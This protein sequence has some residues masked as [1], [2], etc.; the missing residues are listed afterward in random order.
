MFFQLLQQH[1][2]TPL[3]LISKCWQAN[4]EYSAECFLKQLGK[5]E[6]IKFWVKTKKLSCH[7]DHCFVSFALVNKILETAFNILFKR[8]EQ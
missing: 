8:S 3:V 5:S 1:L 6:K 7:V 2:N 4:R